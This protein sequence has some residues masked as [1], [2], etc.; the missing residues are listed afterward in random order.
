MFDTKSVKKLYLLFAICYLIF[1]IGGA[2]A[3]TPTP[4]AGEVGV[5][6]EVKGPSP[7]LSG[8]TTPTP[9]TVSASPT[10]KKQAEEPVK[11]GE[12]AQAGIPK[13]GIQEESKAPENFAEKIIEQADNLLTK[14]NLWLKLLGL[15]WF[16][17]IAFIIFLYVK[18]RKI[19]TPIQTP[20]IG[21]SGGETAPRFPKR[22][23]QNPPEQK[24]G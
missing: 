7:S 11:K 23:H 19:Q 12:E 6:A 22:Q 20:I 3:A 1:T 4:K 18:H 2:S 13:A 14:D 16:I 10:V 17:F 24:A 15:A 5:K 21:P 9:S 8:S